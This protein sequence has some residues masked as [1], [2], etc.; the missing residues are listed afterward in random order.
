MRNL[1]LIIFILGIFNCFAQKSSEDINIF[2][3]N[4]QTKV[5]VYLSFDIS[6]LIINDTNNEY[7]HSFNQPIKI[8]YDDNR[9]LLV[10]LTA[11]IM[12][13]KGFVIGFYG[14]INS[15][16]IY[17]KNIDS[18]L[19]YSAGG[20]FT[21]VRLFPK[22]P[23]HLTIP[24]KAGLGSIGW[25]DN[26]YLYNTVYDTHKQDLYF[27]FEIGANLEINIVKYFKMSAGLTY[28][29]TDAID[30]YAVPQNFLNSW[31]LNSSLIFVIE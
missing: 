16:V 28:K 7:F 24:V 12:L 21:Q 17:D 11:G 3:T 27:V 25:Y 26:I 6:Y 15:E 18:Y 20:L 5:S 30:I 14:N 10:G 9:T 2:S 1:F 23:V 22:Y 29:L 19:R 13:N 4:K 31:Y 8:E